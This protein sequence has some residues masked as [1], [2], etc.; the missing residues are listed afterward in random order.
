MTAFATGSLIIRVTMFKV[1]KKEDQV[2]ML[3]NYEVVEQTNSKVS[4]LR[5]SLLPYLYLISVTILTLP[6]R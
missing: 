3:K 6:G 4:Q 2:T 5:C 1:P